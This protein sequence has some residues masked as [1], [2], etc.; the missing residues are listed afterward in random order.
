[1]MTYGESERACDQYWLLDIDV[2]ICNIQFIKA[3]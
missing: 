3:D 1:M 2:V